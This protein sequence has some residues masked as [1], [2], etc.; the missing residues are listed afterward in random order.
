LERPG[1]VNGALLFAVT[2]IVALA[3]SNWNNRLPCYV[4]ANRV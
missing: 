4:P 3:K 1:V 2:M